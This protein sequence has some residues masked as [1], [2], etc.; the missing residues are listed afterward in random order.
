[1]KMALT[2]RGK[3]RGMSSVAT[4][5]VILSTGPSPAY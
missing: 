3:A 2:G 1:M 4:L 5:S